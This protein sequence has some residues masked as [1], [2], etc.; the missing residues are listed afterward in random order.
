[1]A[2]ATATQTPRS[3]ACEAPAGLIAAG[4]DCDDA[5]ATVNPAAAEVCDGLDNNCD[6]L[7]DGE[8]AADAATWHNDDDGDGYGDPATAQRRLRGPGGRGLRR[9]GLRR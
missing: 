8:D 9:H 6:G 1:M 2:T 3:V 7:A 5:T 4:S